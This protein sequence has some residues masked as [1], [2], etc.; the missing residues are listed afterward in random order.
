MGIFKRRSDSPGRNSEG[1]R[2]QPTVPSRTVPELGAVYIGPSREERLALESLIPAC[3]AAG[4]DA[5]IDE[6]DLCIRARDGR[7][8]VY[9]RAFDTSG[10][11]L[12]EV[13]CPSLAAATNPDVRLDFG[14][15]VHEWPFNAGADTMPAVAVHVTQVDLVDRLAAV[16]S[17]LHRS[18][19]QLRPDK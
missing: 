15:Y 4:F 19:Q 6:S 18:W 1:L 2:A 9:V 8:E 7:E 3:E 14:T 12:F 17:S 13:S 11:P 16:I 10:G 5:W